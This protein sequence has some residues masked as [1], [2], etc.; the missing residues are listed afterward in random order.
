MSEAKSFVRVTELTEDQLARKERAEK[1]ARRLRAAADTQFQ[2]AHDH[3]AMIPM[4]QPILV[5]HH[6]ER[7][8]RRDLE[9]HDRKMRKGLEL[10]RAAER[11][12]SPL[13]GSAILSD[14]PDAIVALRAQLEA[15]RANHELAKRANAAYRRGH[16]RGGTEG[17]IAAMREAGIAEDVIAKGLHHMRL[18]PTYT[19]PFPLRN[20]NAEL[21]R[22]EARIAELEKLEAEPDREPIVGDGWRIE[23]DKADKRIRFYFDERP[24]REV[25]QAM[26]S[27]GW[28]WS[29][30]AGAWQRLLNENG[31]WSAERLARK[32]FGYEPK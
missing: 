1:R 32:L 12:E 14:D 2:Q 28:R 26:K 22:I 25:V 20:G 17:A 24:S 9:K 29:R 5:G 4:G 11:A 31:R 30:N 27:E 15:A 19:V 21:R 13:A 10:S 23:E 18:M 8:H 7:R 16:K 6:S 3:V